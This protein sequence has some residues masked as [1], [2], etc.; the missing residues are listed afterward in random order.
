MARV[1]CA[2]TPATAAMISTRPMAML[3]ILALMVMRLKGAGFRVPV[4]L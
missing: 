2:V 4:P 1:M 3:K